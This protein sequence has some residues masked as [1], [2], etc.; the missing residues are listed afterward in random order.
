MSRGVRRE[1]LSRRHRFRGRDSFRPLLRSS[2]KFAGTYAVLHVAPAT[3][4]VA[5]FGISVGRKAA[6]LSVQRNRI[7][8]RAR[9]TF[10]RHAIKQS[11]VD[12]VL[13]LTSRF[14][15][16]HLDALIVELT[17]LM[18]RARARIAA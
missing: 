18:D 7:K 10:R 6:K 17:D 13:T 4:P 2:R 9:E 1:G 5:R 3:T 11:P 8:R 12:L 14:D 15:A 16:A